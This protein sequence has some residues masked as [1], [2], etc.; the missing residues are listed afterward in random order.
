MVGAQVRVGVGVGIGIGIGV[1]E[2]VSVSG[3][4]NWYQ[5]RGVGIGGIYM[6]VRVG[7]GIGVDVGFRFN[8][9]V[10]VGVCIGIASISAPQYRRLFLLPHSSFSFAFSLF[11]QSSTVCSLQWPPISQPS[12]SSSLSLCNP[13]G[14]SDGLAEPLPGPTTRQAPC[15]YQPSELPSIAP[16]PEF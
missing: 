10:A 7:F 4:R 14:L 6:G 16:R 1:L 12:V 5:Y 11:V 2:L 3:C 8:F 15:V 9:G 13:P